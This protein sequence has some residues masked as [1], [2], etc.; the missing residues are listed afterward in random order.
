MKKYN[1]HKSERLTKKLEESIHNYEYY[2]YSLWYDDAWDDEYYDDIY[3]LTE[4]GLDWYYS[5]KEIIERN[6]TINDVLGIDNDNS[7]LMGFN[8]LNF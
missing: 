2:L 8:P 5:I 6:N 4:E 7:D 3:R 1:R